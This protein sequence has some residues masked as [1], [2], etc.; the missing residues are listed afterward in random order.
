MK[1]NST[2]RD[3]ARTIVGD[4]PLAY[5]ETTGGVK[6]SEEDKVEVGK[7]DVSYAAVGAVEVGVY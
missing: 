1:K 3:V 2:V 6:V 7:N 4:A 5:V